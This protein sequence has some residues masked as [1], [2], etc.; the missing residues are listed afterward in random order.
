MLLGSVK[1]VF[2]VLDLFKAFHR[3]KVVPRVNVLTVALLANV[4]MKKRS[5]TVTTKTLAFW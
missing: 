2:S 5:L 3:D 4:P 1:T